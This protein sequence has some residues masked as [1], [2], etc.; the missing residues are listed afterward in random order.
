MNAHDAAQTWKITIS[1]HS[2]DRNDC[3]S[4]I[5]LRLKGNRAVSRTGISLRIHAS[6]A[7]GD[8]GPFPLSTASTPLPL[9]GGNPS[10]TSRRLCPYSMSPAPAPGHS[11]QGREM[12]IGTKIPS[13][14]QRSPNQS[15][16]KV[17]LFSSLCG[18]KSRESS[19]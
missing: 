12:G 10:P 13:L 5:N 2:W 16:M 3:P 19:S 6:V 15:H 9:P 8:G 17:R 14:G 4:I 11:S 18:L 1:L 7:P